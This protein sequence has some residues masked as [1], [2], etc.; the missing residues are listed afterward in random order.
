MNILTLCVFSLILAV[1]LFNRS[2]QRRIQ[3][4]LQVSKRREF[5]YKLRERERNVKQS[6]HG[7]VQNEEW[8]SS[9]LVIHSLQLHNWSSPPQ[10]LW[11][12]D[13][14]Q[15]C[16]PNHLTISIA[17]LCNLLFVFRRKFISHCFGGQF[18]DNL[19]LSKSQ[20]HEKCHPGSCSLPIWIK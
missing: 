3:V 19:E 10:S 2:H 20:H 9:T 13:R 16:V 14:D 8:N 5:Y 17:T 15:V 4:L 7:K 6:N 12:R 11:S 1:S 18:P